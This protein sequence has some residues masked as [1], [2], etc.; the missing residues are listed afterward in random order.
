[1]AKIAQVTYGIPSWSEKTYTARYNYRCACC[2]GLIPAGTKYLRHVERLGA[3]KGVDPL[4]NVHVH[5][6]CQAP[7][8]QPESPHRLKSVGKLPHRAPPP[9]VHDTAR[10]YHKPSI[11]LVSPT[12][13][14]LQWQPP[15]DLAAKLVAMPNQ[16]ISTGAVVEIESTLTI[17]MTAL[18]Q[19]AGSQRKAKKLSHLI[20]AITHLLDPVPMPQKTM[21]D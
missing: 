5:L 1:M 12:L 2:D 15:I 3:N 4:R 13:G 14:T 7:W 19:A 6:D 18:M 9:D 16:F 10:Y 17:V 8:Y 20:E 11:V 21:G